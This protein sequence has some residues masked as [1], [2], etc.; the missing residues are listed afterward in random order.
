MA[1]RPPRFPAAGWEHS[2]GFAS[3]F[4]P[5]C[6]RLHEGGSPRRLTIQRPTARGAPPLPCNSRSAVRHRRPGAQK[7]QKRQ[8]GQISMGST[9][10]FHMM[11][12][13]ISS[14]MS[15]GTHSEA[16]RD[17]AFQLSTTE[18]SENSCGTILE[19]SWNYPGTTSELRRN[20]PF[21]L[22]FHGFL[23]GQF[24]LPVPLIKIL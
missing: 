9:L 2:R 7:T 1:A 11:V 20:R 13:R 21:I 15:S 19:L 24:L 14:L 6:S 16:S 12:A 3:P 8:V 23:S 17:H 5:G 10:Q 22:C 18:L 4:P